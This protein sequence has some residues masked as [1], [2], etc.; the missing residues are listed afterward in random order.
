MR[1]IAGVLTPTRGSVSLSIDDRPVDEE[2]RIFHLGFVAPY[3][4]MYDGL[5][6]RENLLFVQR[7]RG[8]GAD[9]TKIDEAVRRVGLEGRGDDFISTFSSGM[10]QRARFAVL[11]VVDPRLLL[12][13]EPTSNLDE[14]G[15]EIV[16]GIVTGAIE[17]GK[18]VIIATNSQLERDWCETSLNVGDFAV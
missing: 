3:V 4:Q 17:V 2:H 8:L 1:L 12:L 11:L 15:V 6:L 10:K 7:V 13:D 18:S 14:W 9:R 5:T 16:R